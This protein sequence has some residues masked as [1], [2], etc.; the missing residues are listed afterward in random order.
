MKHE[1]RSDSRTQVNGTHVSIV[2][3]ESGVAFEGAAHDVS[4]DGLMFLSALEPPLGADMDVAV[5]GGPTATL[6][7]LRVTKAGEG[8]EVAGRLSRVA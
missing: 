8:W 2:D 7:V 5:D 6:H 4:I 3:R 1:Q